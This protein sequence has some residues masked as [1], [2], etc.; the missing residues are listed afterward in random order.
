MRLSGTFREPHPCAAGESVLKAVLSG[1]ER[2]R[3]RG[4]V[5]G[6]SPVMRQQLREIALLECGQTFEHVLQISP[7]IVTV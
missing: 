1:S 4:G 6:G 7:R 5:A 3:W 2:R